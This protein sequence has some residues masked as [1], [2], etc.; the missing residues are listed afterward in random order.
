VVLYEFET[1]SDINGG[2]QLKLFENRS[3]SI[4]GPK[5]DEVTRCYIKLRNE[6]LHNLYS[7]PSISRMIRS[8]R[9]G[10]AGHVARIGEKWNSYTIFVGKVEGEIPLGRLRRKWVNNIKWILQKQDGVVWTALISLR[11]D[12]RGEL[13][14]TQ[15]WTS[16]FHKMFG[17]SWVAAQLA[18]SQEGLSSIGLVIINL[19]DVIHGEPG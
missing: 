7:S 11:I 14:W 9:M 10:C 8:R 1:W 12:T 13:L 16:G 6:E 17:N 15:C 4:F 2:T 18:A 5:R 19:S 3:L